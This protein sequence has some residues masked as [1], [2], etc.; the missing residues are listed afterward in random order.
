MGGN[1]IG[2]LE[3]CGGLQMT[4][5]LVD[6][7]RVEK[8]PKRAERS[9]HNEEINVKLYVFWGIDFFRAGFDEVGF[10]FLLLIGFSWG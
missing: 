4:K 8:N 3:R 7:G 10:F 6:R 2:P 1:K 9:Q 5:R